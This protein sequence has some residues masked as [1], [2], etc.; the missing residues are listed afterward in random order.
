MLQWLDETLT[1]AEIPWWITGGTL[2]GAMRHQGFIPHDDDIDIE[3]LEEDLPRA[4][5]ALGT[6]VFFCCCCFFLRVNPVEVT[7]IFVCFS[8]CY[9]QQLSWPGAVD[10]QR[11]PHGPLLFLGPRR[12]F[13]GIGG[14]VPAGGAT[15][16]AAGGVSIRGGRK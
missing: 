1:A 9:W 16:A 10:Q 14:C 2:L 7:H 3:L 8:R 11:R 4:Q 12:A 5:T 6:S 13:L 15:L